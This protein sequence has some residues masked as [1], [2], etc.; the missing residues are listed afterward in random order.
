MEPHLGHQFCDVIA[1]FKRTILYSPAPRQHLGGLL[2]RP[3]EA[4]DG[5]AELRCNG[6][7]RR[8]WLAQA[9]QQIGRGKSVRDDAL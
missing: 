7:R 3:L 6:W 2:D 9:F 4:G 5:A 8:S 1:R